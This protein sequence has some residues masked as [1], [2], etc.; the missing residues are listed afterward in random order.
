MFTY[1]YIYI[2]I[3]LFI[4]IHRH[5]GSE[6]A[7]AP[8]EPPRG[9]GAPG[10]AP[11]GRCIFYC[12]YL[13]C[14]V[15]LCVSLNVACYAHLVLFADRVV[16]LYYHYSLC[17]VALCVSLLLAVF[18]CCSLPTGRCILSPAVC[19]GNSHTVRP[20]CSHKA[21]ARSIHARVCSINARSE[22]VHSGFVSELGREDCLGRTRSVF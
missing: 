12:Q 6:A 5:P 19:L 15:A 1:I 17:C 22:S 8:L 4:F 3:N 21:F 2:Y 10:L 20:A 14:C 18:V 16:H 9:E 13:S 11:T 7:K